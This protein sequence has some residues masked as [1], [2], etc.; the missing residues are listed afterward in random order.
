MMPTQGARVVRWASKEGA[1]RIRYLGRRLGPWLEDSESTHHV[2]A[3]AARRPAGGAANAR[4]QR[5]LDR[6]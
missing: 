1:M 5:I 6:L 2:S 4:T 3:L